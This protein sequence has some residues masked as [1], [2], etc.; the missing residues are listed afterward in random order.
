MA[1]AAPMSLRAYAKRRGCSAEAVSKAVSEGRLR[2]SVVTVNGQPKIADPDAAD[3]EWNAKTRPRIDQ[4]R[5]KPER[6][7]R[8]QKARKKTRET[9]DDDE[10]PQYETS[11]AIREAAA[12]RR[13][14]A[15]ADLAEIEVS[16]KLDEIVPVEEARAYMVDKFTVVKTRILGVPTLVAQRL[17]HLA[18]EVVPLLKELLREVLEELAAETDGDGEE[19]EVEAA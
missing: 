12:A 4:P 1:A 7:P 16:E 14:N 3:L 18:D 9:P 10:V 13:E 5:V 11:R 19:E 15:L 8:R 2:T 17:P 6:K